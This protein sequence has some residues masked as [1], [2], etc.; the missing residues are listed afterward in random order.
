MGS[1][2]PTGTVSRRPD[3]GLGRRDADPGLALAP[4]ELDALAGEVAQRRQ[5]LLGGGQ[6][7]VVVAVRELGQ[8]GP[9]TPATVGVALEQAVRLE[10]DGEAVRGGAGEP[11]ALAQL[12]QAARGDRPRPAAPPPPCRARRF[13]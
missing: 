2:T 13:R 3:G 6:Q 11:G 8:G 1:R 9:G 7:R 4:V 10:A 12:A 5:D